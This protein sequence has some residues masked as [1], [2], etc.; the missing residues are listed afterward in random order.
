LI[1][2][3]RGSKGH[4]PAFEQNENT[5]DR[6]ILFKDSDIHTQNSVE[7][8]PAR[9]RKFEELKPRLEDLEGTASLENSDG[10]KPA[11]EPSE[12]TASSKRGF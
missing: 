3:K 7:V 10:M 4:Q 5:G 11:P 8:L 1:A 9:R 2:R 12:S 6:G